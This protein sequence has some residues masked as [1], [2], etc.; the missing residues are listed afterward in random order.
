MHFFVSRAAH[1]SKLEVSRI[2]K[3]DDDLVLRRKG[4][5]TAL[6]KN[7]GGHAKAYLT[8]GRHFRS[9]GWE[10]PM[11]PIGNRRIVGRRPGYISELLRTR[12]CRQREEV[13]Q[14]QRGIYWH[15]GR[16]LTE[17]KGSEC[18][19]INGDRAEGSSLGKGKIG[20]WSSC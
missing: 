18:G 20:M 12:A 7:V 4:R 6:C 3:E 15:A 11:S 8:A 2:N 16:S 9:A 17:R 19:G 10:N 5:C 1:R 13:L 14:S